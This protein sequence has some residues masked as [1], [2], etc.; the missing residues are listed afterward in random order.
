VLGRGD[1][2]PC[3][4][5]VLKVLL[6]VERFFPCYLD[7]ITIAIASQPPTFGQVDTDKVPMD[8]FTDD[9][10]AADVE[11][12]AY[13][14]SKSDSNEPAPAYDPHAEDHFGEAVVVKDAK[15]IVT[16]VLHVVDDQTL[17]PWTFRAFFL[18]KVS[19]PLYIDLF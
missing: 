7:C 15:D 13:A 11:A 3:S 12:T 4:P 16:T 17:S 18:G 5:P 14:D 9:K 10:K 19:L 2:E 8:S 1:I 6:V